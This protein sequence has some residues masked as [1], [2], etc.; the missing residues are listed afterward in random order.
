MMKWKN[1][2]LIKKS[3]YSTDLWNSNIQDITSRS[4]Y[5]DQECNYSKPTWLKIEKK[6]N[7]LKLLNTVKYSLLSPS[8]EDTP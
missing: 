6:K 5:K 1:T 2:I 3:V 4:K 8:W 7:K